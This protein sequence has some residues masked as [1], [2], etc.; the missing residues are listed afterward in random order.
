[1][2]T[3]STHKIWKSD[4]VLDCVH[5]SLLILPNLPC[6][7]PY[8]PVKMSI[9]S[10]F[11]FLNSPIINYFLHKNISMG[12]GA[13]TYYLFKYQPFYW[14]LN[15]L[16]LCFTLGSLLRNGLKEL[17]F[18]WSSCWLLN[19]SLFFII[20]NISEMLLN[21]HLLSKLP[22]SFLQTNH[23]LRSSSVSGVNLTDIWCLES[24][25][26]MDA[27]ICFLLQ[28]PFGPFGCLLCILGLQHS[29]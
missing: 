13:G 11:R 20:L 3:I 8:S 2:L 15:K 21:P 22:A 17:E 25:W 27:R 16:C 23:R 4:L 14:N 28:D 19:S 18:L 1:M 9:F 7:L 29:A 5:V 10:L 6:E 26:S 12:E 24:V